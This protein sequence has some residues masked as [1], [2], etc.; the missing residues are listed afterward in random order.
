MH[1]QVKK[2]IKS[3]AFL[4]VSYVICRVPDGVGDLV[5][6][7]FGI[8]TYF[9]VT[10]SGVKKKKKSKSFSVPQIEKIQVYG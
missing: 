4:K 6:C 2:E 7:V 3:Q 10:S 5:R 8:K 1:Q 9:N